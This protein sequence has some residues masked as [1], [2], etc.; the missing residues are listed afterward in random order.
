MEIEEMINIQRKC[1]KRAKAIVKRTYR[2]YDRIWTDRIRVTP[3]L[4]ATGLIGKINGIMPNLL[5]RKGEAPDIE[6]TASVYGFAG[7]QALAE[8]LA[9]YEP[10]KKREDAVYKRLAERAFAHLPLDEYQVACDMDTRDLVALLRECKAMARDCTMQA[11]EKYDEIWAG[12]IRIT[13][14]LQKHGKDV[15]AEINGKMPNLLTH[16]PSRSAL[17]QVAMLY[18]FETSQDLVDYL[19]AYEPRRASQEAFCDRLIRET[20]GLAPEVVSEPLDGEIDQV[21][22]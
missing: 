6:E 19:L 20:L 14:E 4:E 12:K 13:P 21:P 22:F 7:G 17:D 15:I 10:R 8:Y 16:D 9:A 11:Y 1:R 5:L 18:D 3:E 2:L